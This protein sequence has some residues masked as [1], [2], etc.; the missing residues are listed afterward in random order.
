MRRSDGRSWA[1]AVLVAVV[2]LAFAGFFVAIEVASRR[3]AADTSAQEA[4]AEA[5]VTRNAQAYA[6]AVVAIGDPTPTDERLAA[7][8]E[9][10]QVEVREVRRVPDLVLTVYGS[11]PFGVVFGVSHVNACHRVTFHDLGTA[12]AGSDVERLAACPTPAP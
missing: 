10:A 12:R 3:A 9:G 7:V 4:E 1:P 6:A 2:A 5:A 8:A 11:A